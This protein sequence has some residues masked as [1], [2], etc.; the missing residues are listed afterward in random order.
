MKMMKNWEGKRIDR[1]SKV[2]RGLWV[3]GLVMCLSGV[4]WIDVVKMSLV[5][6]VHIH[7]TCL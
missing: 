1:T 6:G 5:D 2:I 3:D 4:L 7:Q